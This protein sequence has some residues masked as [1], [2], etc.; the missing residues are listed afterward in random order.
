MGRARI[1]VV[2]VLAAAAMAVPAGR[3]DAATS[4]ITIAHNHLLRNGLPW[5]SLA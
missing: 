3:A 2:V 5:V 1:L 4:V